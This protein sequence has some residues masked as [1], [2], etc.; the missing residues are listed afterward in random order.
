MTI[1][2][3]TSIEELPLEQTNEAL[4]GVNCENFTL[5]TRINIIYPMV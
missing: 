5:V 2:V 3:C 1:P 4:R